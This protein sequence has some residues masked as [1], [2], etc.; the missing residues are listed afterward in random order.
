LVVLSF[1]KRIHIMKSL[2]TIKVFG[3]L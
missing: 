1:D 3:I 2:A